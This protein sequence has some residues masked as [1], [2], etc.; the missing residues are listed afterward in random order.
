M[1]SLSETYAL[2][3]GV[4]LDEPKIHLGFFPLAHAYEKAVL[5]HAFA[6]NNNF[7]SK[8]YDYFN[9]VVSFLKPILDKHGYGLYQIG[10][11]GEPQLKNVTYLCGQIN[12]HQTAFLVKNC[13]LLIGNDSVN[14]HFAGSFNTPLVCLYGPT[15]PKNHG[16]YWRNKEKT[17]LLESHRMNNRRP[18]YAAFEN[19]KTINFIPPE[20]VA[21]AALQNLELKERVNVVSLHIGEAFNNV[22]IEI[23]PEMVVNPQFA[24][25]AVLNVRGDCLFN[26]QMIAQNLAQ[27]KC[28]LFLKQPINIEILKQFKANLVHLRCKLDGD[29][30]KEFI[31]QIRKL[32]VP[33]SFYV[34]KMSEK[35]LTNLRTELFDYCFFDNNIIKTRQNFIESVE[36][37]QNKKLD[38]ELKTDNLYYKSNKFILS[39]KGIFLSKA[40]MDAQI[41]IKSFDDNEQKIIDTEEFW[42]EQ[43]HFYVYKKE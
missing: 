35:D 29:F 39:S 24:Q 8:I 9:E 27:R 26:E 7:P 2:Q 6:G 25:G 41:S 36:R 16:P 15:D 5:I 14:A 38:S 32:G 11:P 3:V 12:L 31:K 19:P 21:N 22:T 33:A 37:Y 13:A 20:Q 40:A 4:K 17:I 18:A 23:I 42:R 43:E 10:G 28:A 34:E 1:S 30:P